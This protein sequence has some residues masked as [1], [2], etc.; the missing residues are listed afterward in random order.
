MRIVNYTEQQALD[1]YNNHLITGHD[2]KEI[3]GLTDWAIEHFYLR[4]GDKFTFRT[5]EITK[6]IEAKPQHS[7]GFN[8]QLVDCVTSQNQVILSE[9]TK[10][11]Q[12]RKNQL[13]WV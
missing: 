7:R 2:A 1:T 8:G 11:L 6:T 13:T 9:E 3:I 10:M 4:S 12:K 5:V